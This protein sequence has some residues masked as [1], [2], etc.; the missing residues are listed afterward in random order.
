MAMIDIEQMKA[1]WAGMKVSQS[2]ME[3]KVDILI[4]KLRKGKLSSAQERLIWQYRKFGTIFPILGICSFFQLYHLTNGF[5]MFFIIVIEVFFLT[6]SIMDFW[7]SYAVSRIDVVN[8][9]VIEIADNAKKLKRRHH[10]FQIILIVLAVVLVTTLCMELYGND[11]W[12]YMMYGLLAGGV[13]GIALGLRLY[14]RIMRD[15]RELINGD[16]NC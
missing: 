16:T 14:F 5:S 9:S 10:L 7:L 8:M 1:S 13:V 3:K 6:A 12:E 15:Y 2:E 4:G 11:D